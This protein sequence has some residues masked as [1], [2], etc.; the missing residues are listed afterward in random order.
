MIEGRLMLR[1]PSV[2]TE[3]H[4]PAS[5][6][7]DSQGVTEFCAAF[8]ARAICTSKQ[9]ATEKV[10]PLRTEGVIVS[11]SGG[12]V[13]APAVPGEVCGAAPRHSRET[14]VPAPGRE[15]TRA[16]PPRSDSTRARML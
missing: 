16:E 2:N 8:T 7:S 6:S 10:T 15:S 14:T 3:S 5:V 11:H 9:A 12:V 4:T 13:A 1:Q